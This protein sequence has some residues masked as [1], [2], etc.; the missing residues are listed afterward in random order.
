[1]TSSSSMFKKQSEILENLSLT[2]GLSVSSLI[3][4]SIPATYC[5]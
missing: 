5:L 1:M 2:K 3:S 4:L